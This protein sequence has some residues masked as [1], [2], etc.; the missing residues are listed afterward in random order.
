[1]TQ[2]PFLKSIADFMMVR[3]YSRRTIDSYVYW[4]KYFIVFNGKQH[5]SQLGDV[6]IERFLTHLAV[7]RQVAQSTQAIALNA[8]VFLKT[9]FLN[10]EVG[11]VSAFSRASRQRKL[12]VVLTKDEVSALLQTVSGIQKLMLSILYGSGLRRIELVRCKS[13]GY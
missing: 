11:N 4:I 12:P 7:N 9:K 2:S 5:P 8:I 10:Q 1:M 3:N 6:A 13:E